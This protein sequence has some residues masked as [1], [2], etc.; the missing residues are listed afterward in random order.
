MEDES[1][2]EATVYVRYDDGSESEFE[3]TIECFN[4]DIE[5]ISAYVCSELNS[6]KK[7]IAIGSLILDSRLIVAVGFK[8][9]EDD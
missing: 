7:F 1:T 5:T 2:L 6:E 3:T 4:N 8:E 9:D